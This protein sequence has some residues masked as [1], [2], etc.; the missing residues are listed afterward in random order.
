MVDEYLVYAYQPFFQLP[1]QIPLW[2]MNTPLV[3]AGVA[4]FKSSDSSMVDEYESLVDYG[5]LPESV[6]IPLWSMNTI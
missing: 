4:S 3:A 5:P 2:S 1:V 6:Q